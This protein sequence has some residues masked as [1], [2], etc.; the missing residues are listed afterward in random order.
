MLVH[1]LFPGL[2][3][4]PEHIAH[5]HNLR[6]RLGQ[7]RGHDTAPA[8]A[9]TDYP[10]RNALARRRAAFRTQRRARHKVRRRQ[11]AANSRGRPPQKRTPAQLMTSL[12]STH[13]VFS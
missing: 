2:A 1:L 13:A 12:R 6:I 3:P 11:S 7:K 5:R 10:H 4:V 8:A 9:Q